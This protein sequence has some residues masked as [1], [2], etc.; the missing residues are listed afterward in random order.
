LSNHVYCLHNVVAA[1]L[2]TKEEVKERDVEDEIKVNQYDYIFSIY[3]SKERKLEG[4]RYLPITVRRCYLS[5][6]GLHSSNITDNAMIGLSNYDKSE[7]FDTATK[8][9]LIA[10]LVD[11]VANSLRKSTLCPNKVLLKEAADALQERGRLL[12]DNPSA[13]SHQF[14]SQLKALS[15]EWLVEMGLGRERKVVD[16]NFSF[17]ELSFQEAAESYEAYKE[18]GRIAVCFDH[19][20]AF[21]KEQKAY[22]YIFHAEAGKWPSDF[23]TKPKQFMLGWGYKL[24]QDPRFGDLAVYW[25]QVSKPH[26]AT[27]WGIVQEEGRIR[28]KMGILP[29]VVEH[30]VDD[31]LIE[32][33]DNVFFFRKD[34]GRSREIPL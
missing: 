34:M 10:Q 2:S 17:S 19:A 12:R 13:D 8:Q 3:P 29:P 7:P 6:I 18:N 30:D 11:K 14:F 23:F 27:H 20:M 32:Y 1:K 28:S 16:S 9:N 22:P 31:V 25:S 21:L 33:G 4:A 5:E 24:V 15:F 26:R